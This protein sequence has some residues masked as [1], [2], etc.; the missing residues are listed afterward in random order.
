[1]LL[2]CFINTLKLFFVLLRIIVYIFHFNIIRVLLLFRFFFLLCLI[3][4]RLY[5][6]W[7][8]VFNRKR[9]TYLKDTNSGRRKE[10]W[11]CAIKIDVDVINNLIDNVRCNMERTTRLRSV[12]AEHLETADWMDQVLP[13]REVTVRNEVNKISVRAG[14]CRYGKMERIGRYKMERSTRLRPLRPEHIETAEWMDKVYQ[15]RKVT[16]RN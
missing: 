9:I 15:E 3:L 14:I 8:F 11:D 4:F 7:S 13:E 2:Q 12:R 5:R 6:L 1:M 10:W 16:V